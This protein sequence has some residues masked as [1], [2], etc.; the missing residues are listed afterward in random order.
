MRG[1]DHFA[2]S[3]IKGEKERNKFRRRTPLAVVA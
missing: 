3:A 1:H 2:L